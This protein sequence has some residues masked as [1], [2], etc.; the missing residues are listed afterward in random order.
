MVFASDMPFDPEDGAGYIQRTLRDVENL[1]IPQEQ[2]EDILYR[3]A[4]RIL[5]L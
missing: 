2:K 4:V 5:G 1:P 3:N